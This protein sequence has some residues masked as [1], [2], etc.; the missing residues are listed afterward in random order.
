MFE[1]F[2]HPFMI[3]ALLVGLLMA[4]STGL[5]SSF[6]VSSNQSLIGDGLA[7]TTFTGIVIGIILGN[8]PLYIAIPFT[9]IVA[10]IIKSLTY[11]KLEGDAAIGLVSTFI[12]AVGFILISL[13]KGFNQSIESILVGSIFS[14]TWAD[15]LVVGVISLI[16]ISFITSSYSELVSI[17][18]DETYAKFNKINVKLY[19][20]L[21]TIIT[22]VIVVLGVKTI[23]T[24]LISA[25]I[26]FPAVS[27]NLISKSFKEMIIKGVII[28]ILVS[29]G[30]IILSHYLNLQ[31]GATIIFLHGI[32]FMV[33]Y[34][35]KK[36]LRKE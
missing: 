13:S 29:L 26:I 22:A 34:G 18:F 16:L 28:N 31:A 7:H 20:Y 27:A 6:L 1:I 9:I 8:N 35:Y 23:G 12:I 33:L 15:I 17:T 5:L 24:L 32:L 11:T 4:I 10:V 19:D 21:F 14:T 3:R 25:F 2:T 36:L 30:G